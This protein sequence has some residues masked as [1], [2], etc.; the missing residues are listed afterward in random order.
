MTGGRGRSRLASNQNI[1]ARLLLSARHRVSIKMFVH[2]GHTQNKLLREML[3]S[4]TV[5]PDEEVV[6]GLVVQSRNVLLLQLFC[7]SNRS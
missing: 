5:R 6:D 4:V 7:D 2:T 3:G 1:W